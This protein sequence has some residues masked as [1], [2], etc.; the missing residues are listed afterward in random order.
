MEQLATQPAVA[1]TG[2][3][4]SVSAVKIE[5]DLR[6]TLAGLHAE[7]WASLVRSAEWIVGDRG[8]AEE[9]VQDAFVRLVE[10]WSRLKD[11]GAAPAWLRKTTVNLCRSRVRRFV[12]G[13]RKRDQLG[14]SLRVVDASSEQLGEELADGPLGQAIRRLPDR[15]RECVALRFVHDLSLDDVAATLGISPGSVKTHLHRALAR[16]KDTHPV[17]AAGSLLNPTV[18]TNATASKES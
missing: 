8:L 9:I 16:L 1:L 7:H 3:R 10:N 14:A 2:A 11:P 18:P 5:P 13:R 4:P 12:I 15:Q 6:A 17:P